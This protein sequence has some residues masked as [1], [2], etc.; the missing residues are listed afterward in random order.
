MTVKRLNKRQGPWLC[1]DCINVPMDQPHAEDLFCVCKKV[2]IYLQDKG[3][4][5]DF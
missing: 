1:D 5:F 4:P 2:R 3:L